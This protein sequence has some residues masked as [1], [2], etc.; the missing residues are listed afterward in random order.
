MRNHLKMLILSA[1]LALSSC[2]A[3]DNTI[4]KGVLGGKELVTHASE[5]IG[6]LK[7]EVLEEISQLKTET[8]AEVRETVEEVMPRVVESILDADAVAFLI[9]AVA[10]L[11]CFV[12]VSLLLLILGASR[13]AYK[14]WSRQ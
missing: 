1:I 3:L 11:G 9:V 12:V 4:D 10:G 8:L 2:S 5:E 7:T 6:K 13:A 14:R